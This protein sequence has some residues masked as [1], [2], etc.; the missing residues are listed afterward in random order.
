V[1]VVKFGGTSVGD[2][3]AIGRA[4]EIVRGR[5]PGRPLV[6]VSAMAGVTNALIGIAEQASRGHL[7][8]AVQAVEALRGPHSSPTNPRPPK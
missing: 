4:A 5:M 8:G 1:I 2:A 7:V 3:A 6:V